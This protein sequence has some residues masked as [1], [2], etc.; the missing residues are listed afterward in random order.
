[1][2]IKSFDIFILN[3]MRLKPKRIFLLTFYVFF[4]KETLKLLFNNKEGTPTQYSNEANSV[5]IFSQND[6]INSLTTGSERATKEAVCRR[7]DHV[8]Y[9][10]THKTGSTTLAHIFWRYRETRT[11]FCWS[12]T[13]HEYKSDTTAVTLTLTL[14]RSWFSSNIKMIQIILQNQGGSA[15]RIA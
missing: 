4:A 2:E 10:K 5:F 14:T 12:H 6:N 7:K 3:E 8:V 13:I 9:I 1:M 11:P 15:R